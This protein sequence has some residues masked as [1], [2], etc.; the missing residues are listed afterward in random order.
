MKIPHI[1]RTIRNTKRLT[2]IG[3]VLSR[4][5]FRQIIIDSGLHAFLEKKRDDIESDS[6][7]LNQPK[8]VRVRLVLEE[9]GPT[10]IKLGQILAT[11]SDLIPSEWC[12][13][14]R[15]LQ[16]RRTPVSYDEIEQVLEQEFPGRLDQLFL[17]I[18]KEPLAAAS[19]AQVHRAT[20]QN[21][22]KTV[23]K[24]IRPGNREIIEEDISLVETISQIVEQYFFNLG[25]SPTAVAKEFS[26]QILREIDL[27]NEGQSTDRLRKYFLNDSKINFPKV[28]W[29]ASTR[30]VL[31]LE[32]IEGR[33]LSEIA[34]E[35]LSMTRRRTI[36]A[37][38]TDAVF[39]QC[40]EFGFFH[41]DPHPGNIILQPED[42]LC[43]IDCGMTGRLDKKTTEQLIN[44]VTGI[45]N[46]DTEKLRKVVLELTDVDP[47]VTNSREFQVEL[48][49]LAGQFQTDSLDNLDIV[50]LLA[51]FFSLLQRFHIRCPGDLLLL[52]KALTTIEG[53]AEQ[54]APDFDVISHVKPQIEE[55]ILNR[56]SM[57][58][59]YKRLNNAAGN[60][61]ELLEEIPGDIHSF[62]SRFRHN[63]FTLNLELKRIEHLG[64]R[65]DTSSRIMGI[66]MIISA[67]VV[68]S[69]ILILADS[70]SQKT[71]F[72]GTLG[73]LGLIAAGISTAGF[74][75]SFLLPKRNNR[76]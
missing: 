15:K 23:L 27:I 63:R 36:V 6:H 20:L 59:I 45:I 7:I 16:S 43:F 38:G 28:F 72:L 49:N 76:D 8:A 40:L 21:G 37:H 44:L 9:L 25:Y 1:K 57:K 11:R 5:G 56:Y 58:T 75:I 17:S 62:L 53:I 29:E 47:T 74:I 54:F 61:L 41:A 39:K 55:I 48:L 22:T 67:T 46:T 3:G 2:E 32:E 50:S 26:R 33:L 34:P 60:Y 71:G 10:F 70:L 52:T 31:C 18:D 35:S 24:I 30:S 4:F 65:I 73:L 66:S 42:S 69:S 19:I 14:F 51:D 13:E 12:T 64:D 68:G